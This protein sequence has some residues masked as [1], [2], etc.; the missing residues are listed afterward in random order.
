M[1]KHIRSALDKG[2]FGCEIFIDLQKAF[3]IVDIKI[4]LKK[5]AYYGI[6]GVSNSWFESF[7]TNR[8]QF[9][10]I[11]GSKPNICDVNVGVPQEWFTP[12]THNNTQSTKMSQRGGLCVQAFDTKFYGRHSFK[13]SA[14]SD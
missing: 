5:L 11:N 7:I 6:R 8:K 9:V 4:L 14:I 2:L 3:D 13:N 12:L 10:S 1:T